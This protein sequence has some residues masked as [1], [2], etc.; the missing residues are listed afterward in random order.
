M[1]SLN[2]TISAHQKGQHLAWQDRVL[3]QVLRQQG[4]S[5]RQI[6]ASL[7]CSPTTVKYELERSQISLYHG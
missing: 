5:L 7:T 4:Q 3:I 1:N 6:A 2:S